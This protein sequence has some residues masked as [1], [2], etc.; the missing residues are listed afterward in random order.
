M[1][2]RHYHVGC[3]FVMWLG[4]DIGVRVRERGCLGGKARKAC[5][6]KDELVQKPPK[7]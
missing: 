3:Q 6:E 2:A 1:W 7:T 5:E 4:I